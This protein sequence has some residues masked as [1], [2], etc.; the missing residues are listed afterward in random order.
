MILDLLIIP[1]NLLFN[2]LIKQDSAIMEV[3]LLKKFYSIDMGVFSNPEKLYFYHFSMYHSLYLMERIINQ[4]KRKYFLYSHF[5]NI[6][7]LKL[8]PEG[9]C[10]YYNENTNIF[11]K[12]KIENLDLSRYYCKEHFVDTDYIDILS[13]RYFYLDKNNLIKFSYKNIEN[14]LNKINKYFFNAQ[15]I[16]SAFNTLEMK[17]NQNLDKNMLRKQFLYLAK[18]YHPDITGNDSTFKKINSAYIFLNKV[19]FEK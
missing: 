14:I 8:P 19:L 7:L 3:E 10:H 4:N 5:M 18:K 9:Y 13:D 16:M 1:H 11:C 12:K 6:R 15:E 2:F 17:P